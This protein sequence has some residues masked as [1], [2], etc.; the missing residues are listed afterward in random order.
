MKLIGRL[1]GQ[2]VT[3]L[4]QLACGLAL[5]GLAIMSFSIISGRPLP[6]VLAMSL[7]HVVGVTSLACFF[8]AVLLD[9]TRRM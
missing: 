6:V 8:L 5:L 2:P 3:R 7:G 9:A 4:V 1:I